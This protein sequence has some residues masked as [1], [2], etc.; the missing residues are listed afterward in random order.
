MKKLSFII[1]FLLGL[2]SLAKAQWT[3]PGNGTTYT[4]DDLVNVSGGCVVGNNSMV[5]TVIADVTISPT[6]K[7]LLLDGKQIYMLDATLTIKGAMIA[8]GSEDLHCWIGG[9]S[10]SNHASL[11]LEDCTERCHFT[12]VLF[13]Y[14]TELQVIGSEVSFVNSD[15][16]HFRA[17]SRSEAVNFMNCNPVFDNCL[18]ENN[19]GAAIS[20]P[21]NGKGS[22]QIT[23]CTFHNNVTSNI[24]QPQINLGPGA[25]DTI[26]I[27]NCT[28]EGGGYDMSGGIAIADLMNTDETKILLKNNV[29][30][31]NRYGYNQQGYNLSSLIIDNRFIDNNT[32]TNPMNGGSGISIYGMN[33]NNKAK[34]RR[35]QISG[36]LWGITA[37]YYH[38]IDMGTEDDWGGNAIFGNEN[39]GTEYAL[40]D[41]GYSDITAIGNYWGDNNPE[42][43]EQ[44][45]FHRPD[46]GET[47]GLVN[48]QPINELHPEVLRLIA[49]HGP[50][51]NGLFS[52]DYEGTIH[53]EDHTID[54]FI[55]EEELYTYLINMVLV[56]PVGASSDFPTSIF[57]DLSDPLT[58]TVTRPH[59]ESQEWTIYLTSNWNTDENAHETFNLFYDR[60]QHA[61]RLTNPMEVEAFVSICNALGQTVYTGRLGAGQQNIDISTLPKGLYVVSLA[62]G[63]R[64]CSQKLIVD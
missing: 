59:G 21:V 6:D 51:N 24:N 61:I 31:N 23:N 10:N 37:I 1:A 38:D 52:T 14:L 29:V 22:P 16:R 41:N 58:F 28:I 26:R 53:P 17:S 43:A 20:S 4:I 32:E 5:F 44:V 39:G 57:I 45:I 13:T 42:Y 50:Y 8:E 19:E 27:V 35:N 40:Y 18:F 11:R 64:N 49:P 15:F 3:S 12:K 46:L 54:L 60:S 62:A 55:P 30:K 2:T 9:D 47:Y 63:R 33:T 34:L 56:L 36:N 48:Y 7:L 25:A